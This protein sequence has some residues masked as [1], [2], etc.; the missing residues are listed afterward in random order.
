[1]RTFYRIRQFFKSLFV[2][3]SMVDMD[4]VRKHLTPA[5]EA[6]FLRMQTYDRYH[7][8]LFAKTL[9]AEVYKVQEDMIVA[10]L[11]HDVGKSR[12][13][14]SPFNRTFAVLIHK[15]APKMMEDATLENVTFFNKTF[16]VAKH[17][18]QWSEEMARSVGVSELTA[19]II[20]S[21]ENENINETH[22]YYEMIKTFIK[23]DDIT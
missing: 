8:V 10:A 15:F 23:Y 6:L 20:A 2:T 21:H 5:Q 11:L 1:M 18:A 9:I 19:I 3:K 16:L 13:L 17:H 4:F 22:P 7:S 12:Y 14:I